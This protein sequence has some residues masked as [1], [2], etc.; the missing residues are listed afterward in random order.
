M[1]KAKK[2][3]IILTLILAIFILSSAL[4]SAQSTE[5]KIMI[6]RLTNTGVAAGYEN[7]TTYSFPHAIGQIIR[8]FLALL[9]VVFMAY[10]TWAG[11]LWMI[12]RGDEEKITKSKA[13]I[14]GSIIGLII[15]LSAYI[16][17]AT[18]VDRFTKAGGQN[19]ILDEKR[20]GGGEKKNNFHG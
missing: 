1:R 6:K 14:R 4:V 10:I 8:A 19:I 2:I 16:I 12:A 20:G 7:I 3:T 5:D 13:I 17:T 9:G 11:Y 18:V 15:V